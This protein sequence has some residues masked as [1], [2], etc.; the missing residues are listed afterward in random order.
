MTTAAETAVVQNARRGVVSRVRE[1]IIVRRFC[2]RRAF[3]RNRNDTGST[4]TCIVDLCNDEPSFQ[5]PVSA[6]QPRLTNTGRRTFPEPRGLETRVGDLATRQLWASSFQ[7]VVGFAS[8]S[9]SISI[10]TSGTFESPTSAALSR[11]P[12]PNTARFVAAVPWNATLAGWFG[13]VSAKAPLYLKVSGTTLV[14]P[15]M[16][17]EPSILQRSAE[18]R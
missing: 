12:M 1:G 16:V 3:I 13:F 6:R 5:R 15:C 2:L 7:G 14:M 8:A 4:P 10:S 9:T 11:A 18:T 17:S